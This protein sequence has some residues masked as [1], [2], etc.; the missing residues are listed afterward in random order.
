[1]MRKL[2]AGLLI[3][4]LMSGCAGLP[5]M[6]V[7]EGC[8]NSLSYKVPGFIPIGPAAIRMA[9]FDFAVLVPQAIP[10]IK[11]GV[12]LA[13]GFIQGGNIIE[14]IF[15]LSAIFSLKYAQSTEAK[16]ILA[17]A[18]LNVRLIVDYYNAG[19]KLDITDCDKQ[20]W[21][22]LCNN[23]LQDLVLVK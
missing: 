15:A 13:Q 6:P 12:N 10:D 3:I 4:A 14:G 1:M 11:A 18:I 19:N 23:I 8:E 21:L 17:S 22:S 20:L 5:K 7:P 16:L 9:I 2:C